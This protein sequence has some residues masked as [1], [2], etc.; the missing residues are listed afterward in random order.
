MLEEREGRAVSPER[1]KTLRRGCVGLVQDR[2]GRT[3]GLPPMHIAFGDVESHGR[4]ADLGKALAHVEAAEKDVLHW[5]RQL[6]ISEDATRKYGTRWSA[7]DPYTGITRNA[8]ENME[9]IREN[10]DT[11]QENA[12]TA[13][14]R[15]PE[16][17]NLEE[18]K[19]AKSAAKL[20]GN[21]RVFDRVSGYLDELNKIFAANPGDAAEV[22]R[23][24]QSHP[25]L[26]PLQGIERFLPTGGR[27]EEFEAVIT[28]KDLWSGQKDSGVR[29]I[30]L[31]NGAFNYDDG[32]DTPDPSR[33]RPNPETGRVDMSRDLHQG[34]P[35]SMNFN[36]AYYDRETN[37]WWGADQGDHDPNRPMRVKQMTPEYLWADRLEYDTPVFGVD[38]V[39]KSR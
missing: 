3:D 26:G 12:R 19:D 17:H 23:L 25:D 5:Q 28:Y 32:T 14:A 34:R 36:Y 8:T 6:D 30:D 31:G 38:I 10:L 1:R 2:I 11:A 29:T 4:I 27:P 21:R 7:E 39:D 13:L 18:M 37:S 15:V 9:W 20:E 24:I 22:A 16:G 35:N 33:F